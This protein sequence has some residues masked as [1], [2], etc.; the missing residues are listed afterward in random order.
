LLT[1]IPVPSSL[2]S[3]VGDDLPG[4]AGVVCVLMEEDNVTDDGAEAGHAALNAAVATALDDIIATRSF[5]NRDITQAEIDQYLDAVA[6]AVAD[7]VKSQQSF[8]ENI[9]SWLNEDDTVGSRVFFWAYDD[10]VGGSG[11]DFT[12]RWTDEGD[13]ELFGHVNAAVACSA[14]AAAAAAAS[15]DEIFRR[16]QPDMRRFRDEAFGGTQLPQWWSLADRNAPQLAR[17]LASDAE[18]PQALAE[19]LRAVPQAL[20]DRDTQIPDQ[21]VARAQTVLERLRDSGSRRARMDASRAP[22]A[23]AHLR[24]RTFA[25]A[26]E[27]TSLVPP[28]RTPRPVRDISGLLNSKLRSPPS[29]RDP[30]KARGRPDRRPTDDE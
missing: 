21:L 27:F 29:L 2:Q 12:E 15:L 1:P 8:F 26:I 16:V 30:I 28:A 9:W 14:E 6:D 20:A 4:V 23:L 3:V 5:S 24:G 7:A 13:W 17:I 18:A 22:D 11:I 25:E 19:L 10:L